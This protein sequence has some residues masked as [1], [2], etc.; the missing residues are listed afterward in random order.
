MKSTYSKKQVMSDLLSSAALK[1][2]VENKSA[3]AG[4]I[5]SDLYLGATYFVS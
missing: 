1:S 5:Q 3:G 4:L 2:H